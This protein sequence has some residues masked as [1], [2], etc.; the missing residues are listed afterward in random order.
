[1]ARQAQ[2]ELQTQLDALAQAGPERTSR[3]VDLVLHDAVRRAASD[4]H[5]EPTYNAV[6]L[7]YR[8]DGVLHRVAALDRELAANLVARLKVLAE[9][10]TYRIDIPQEGSIRE[11]A[12]GFGVEMRVSTFPTIHGEKV[13]VRLFDAS[14]R[15]L[16]LDELGFDLDLLAQVKTLLRE[17]TGAILLTG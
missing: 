15:V 11:A 9:L 2:P 4:V 1:M 7:R 17:R 10:L 8:L 13:V 3:L 5:F 14:G 6:E 12:G 16:D